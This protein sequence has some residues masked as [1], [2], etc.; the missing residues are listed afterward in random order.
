MTRS[1][2]LFLKLF[3]LLIAIFFLTARP[4]SLALAS[5]RAEDLF[6]KAGELY[7]A[8]NYTAAKETYERAGKE[9]ARAGKDEMARACRV[10]VIQIEK[11]F[12]DYSLDE[13]AAR[14]TLADEFDFLSENER[15][16]LLAGAESMM[17]DG[18][19]R[20]FGS[21]A[22]NARYRNPELMLKDS[23]KIKTFDTFLDRTKD[24]IYRDPKSNFQAKAYQPYINPITYFGSTGFDI[25]RKKLPPAGAFKAWLPLPVTTASQQDFRIVS[26]TPAEYMKALPDCDRD[27]NNAYFEIPL[28]KIKG[29]LHIR[30]E[31]TYTRYEERFIIEPD[32]VGQYDRNGEI[33]KTYTRSYGHT[34]IT[35]GIEKTAREIAG[36]ETN[37]YLVAKKLYD[38]VFGDVKYSYMPH[39]ALGVLDISESVYVHENRF[40]DCGAQSMYFSALCRSLGI[41]A[42]A[43]GGYQLIPD[44]AGAHFWAEFYLPNYGWVP[45]DTSVAQLVVYRPRLTA[46]QKRR[47]KEY[48][49]GNLDPYRFMIQ[50]DVDRTLTPRP[51]VPPLFPGAIQN[52]HVECLEYKGNP[53]D[54][55]KFWKQDIV[56]LAK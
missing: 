1:Q 18:R 26:V 33:F 31:F 6:E 50:K 36:A 41:P 27:I 17:I 4:V 51:A 49:F 15:N 32:N 12:L 11:I 16:A 39:L 2:K 21:I 8:A 23:K 25:P 24:I 55:L 19:K 38:H 47:F 22:A 7:N 43:C 10:G 37:P 42:R 54:F 45:V 35:A 53:V 30:I 9:Y 13:K 29:D 40:G 3:V 20:Y 14:K 28:D 46:E 34:E 48:F 56:P 44:L 5:P 52:P